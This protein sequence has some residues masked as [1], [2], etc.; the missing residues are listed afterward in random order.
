MVLFEVEQKFNFTLR[1]LHW[2][3]QAINHPRNYRPRLKLEYCG[4]S[5]FCDTYFDTH[6]RLSKQ[7]LWVRKRCISSKS[8]RWEAKQRSD[9]SDSNFAQTT[10]EETEDVDRIQKMVQ[11]HTHAALDSTSNFGLEPFA[12]FTTERSTFKAAKGKF[13]IVLD[14]TDFG[15]RVGEVEMMAE[16]AEQ[17]HAEIDTFMKKHAWFF[18]RSEKP[19]G[20]LT[21]Y[22]EKHGYLGKE[23]RERA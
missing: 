23:S 17:A 7:G 8:D 13:T 3:L 4:Q 22:L 21:A 1:S 16:D 18:D 6:Q 14:K 2:F 20:K 11:I 10:F 15:H 9:T 5:V 19:I 12:E